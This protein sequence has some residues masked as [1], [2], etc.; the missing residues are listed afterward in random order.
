MIIWVLY[1]ISD[2]KARNRAV[3]HCK[4][5]GLYRVQK[6]IFL[7]TLNKNEKDELKIMLEDLVDINT[8]SIYIFPADKDLLY[9]TDLIGKGFDRELICNDIISKFL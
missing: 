7:G 5:K 9:E 1:D 6:S 8:D 2:N 3:K 4:N